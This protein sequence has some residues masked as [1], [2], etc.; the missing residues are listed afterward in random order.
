[1]RIV[2]P[3]VIVEDDLEM[4]MPNGLTMAQH[5][6]KKIEMFTRQC[7]KSE[8]KM[9][10]TSYEKFLQGVFQTRR[11]TGISHHRV[12][13][14]TFL[15]DRGVS[16]EGLRH[17]MAAPY[18]FEQGEVE[19]MMTPF[20]TGLPETWLQESTRYVDYVE[21][22]VNKGCTFIMPPWM[23]PVYESVARRKEWWEFL[24]D[25]KVQ[26]ALYQ[27]WR[28]RGWQPEQARG[29][30]PQF[31]KTQYTASMSLGSW[32]NFCFKRTPNEAHPQI[33]QL[34]IPL[35]RYLTQ[36]L[37]PF[38]TNLPEMKE[39]EEV[40]KFWHQHRGAEPVLYEEAKLVVRPFYDD[41]QF[42]EVYSS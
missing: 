2:K 27:K 1:M 38:F 17:V 37:K 31:A 3:L 34:A 7:Y 16:H 4:T 33:R 21:G 35:R 30:L 22:G 32:W 15:T 29:W 11:H 12:I 6:M 42:E 10:D 40:G 25:L 13:S 18:L 28:N 39:C 14:V 20:E 41:V 24:N 36:F 5:S 8:G 23:Q 19:T 9:T 26:D